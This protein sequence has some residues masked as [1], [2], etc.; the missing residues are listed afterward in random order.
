MF[1]VTTLSAKEHVFILFFSLLLFILTLKKLN[2]QADV[3]AGLQ[4]RAII[5]L[6]WLDFYCMF[7]N[8]IL[9]SIKKKIK[10]YLGNWLDINV[11]QVA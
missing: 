5:R 11:K 10:L 4:P 9:F 6:N 8:K 1:F 3:R 7:T 2:V